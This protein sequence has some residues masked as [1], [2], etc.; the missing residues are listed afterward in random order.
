[1]RAAKRLA[2]AND[3]LDKTE[4]EHRLALESLDQAE[5]LYYRDPVSAE[6]VQPQTVDGDR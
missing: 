6:G 1:M 2:A 5:A 3:E 4:T